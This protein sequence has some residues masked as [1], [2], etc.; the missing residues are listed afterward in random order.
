MRA[1]DDLTQV[2]E[3]LSVGDRL[4]A[5]AAQRPLS[6]PV[7]LGRHFFSDLQEAATDVM[8]Q[9]QKKKEGREGWWRLFVEQEE[10]TEAVR[11]MIE[12]FRGGE[13]LRT[14]LCRPRQLFYL[15]KEPPLVNIQ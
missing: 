7:R 11:T 15:R 6:A 3:N 12:C 2:G 10:A 9:C 1:R 13:E 5:A 14:A 4:V 8:A